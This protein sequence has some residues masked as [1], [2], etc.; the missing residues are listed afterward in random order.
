M[1]AYAEGRWLEA[2]AALDEAARL[3]PGAPG[4][5]FFGGVCRL[6]AGDPDAGARA[7]SR[8]VDL[9]ETAYLEDALLYLARARL[10]QRDGPAARAL[11]ER[12]EDLGGERAS[13]ARE[14]RR[15]LAAATD[16]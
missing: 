3:D 1:Q 2:A 8:V 9:G 11:L 6:L 4:P 12:V 14:L 10:L 5:A 13:E 16:G 7:L 15:Q